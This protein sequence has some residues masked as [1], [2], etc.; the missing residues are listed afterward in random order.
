MGNE[1]TNKVK[2]LTLRAWQ[3]FIIGFMFL[4]PSLWPNVLGFFLFKA[5]RPLPS[6]IMATWLSLFILLKFLVLCR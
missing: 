6:I 5:Q 2:N 3:N 4:I 1:K